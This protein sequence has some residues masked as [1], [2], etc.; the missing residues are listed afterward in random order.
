MLAVLGLALYFGFIIF[1]LVLMLNLLI[2][3]MSDTY[4]RTFSEG[5]LRWRYEFARQVLRLETLNPHLSFHAGKLD[6]VLKPDLGKYCTEIL[7]MDPT[8]DG[9]KYNG[10]G[11]QPDG[12]DFFTNDSTT[13]TEHNAATVTEWQVG[14]LRDTGSLN[15]GPLTSTL[16]SPSINPP[17]SFPPS[18]PFTLLSLVFLIPPPP[19]PCVNLSNAF[20]YLLPDLSNDRGCV[21]STFLTFGLLCWKFVSIFPGSDCL[22][23]P[24][25]GTKNTKKSA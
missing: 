18:K 6:E 8:I 13:E 9:G 19:D 1:S 14:C 7:Q 24:G 15:R 17:F 23:R 4:S 5:E 11:Q 16:F 10:D 12:S 2:A 25:M 22:Y 20:P 3:Q 21:L